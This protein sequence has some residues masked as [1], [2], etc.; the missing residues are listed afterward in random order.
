MYKYRAT[1][2]RVVDGD[3]VDVI[4]DLGFDVHLKARI[5][6]YGINT[7]EIRTRDLEEKERGL[8]AKF[9]VEE[10]L[11]D[12]N[13][14]LQSREYNKGKYGRI[15]ADIIVVDPEGQVNIN[16]LLLEE[17]HAVKYA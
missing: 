16:N 1:L 4:I 9:R 5:R 11:K 7:P 10:L 6:L 8:A 12:R 3:T 2:D 14:I 15:L 13:L 17:G